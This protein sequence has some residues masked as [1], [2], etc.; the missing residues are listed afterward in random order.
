MRG[1]EQIAKSLV[2]DRA[3]PW[4]IAALLIVFLALVGLTFLGKPAS[5]MMII[6]DDDG[7]L[8][9]VEVDRFKTLLDRPLPEYIDWSEPLDQET[10]S[11]HYR[12][13]L[14]PG[15]QDRSLIARG[16]MNWI[17]RSPAI[18][19][20]TSTVDSNDVAKA[21]EGS[22]WRSQTRDKLVSPIPRSS[23]IHI[24]RIPPRKAKAKG[25]GHVRPDSD[26][27]AVWLKPIQLARRPLG[28]KT[29]RAVAGTANSSRAH[30]LEP[31]A[32]SVGWLFA[33]VQCDA[34]GGCKLSRKD[35]ADCLKP[36]TLADHV[37]GMTHLVIPRTYLYPSI[38]K[39]NSDKKQAK[40]GVTDLLEGGGLVLL[41][42]ADYDYVSLRVSHHPAG[43]PPPTD[44]VEKANA[45]V[46]EPADTNEK[47]DSKAEK[48][49]PTKEYS[50]AMLD[51]RL[52]EILAMINRAEDLND[53]DLVLILPTALDFNLGAG[54]YLI[55]GFDEIPP[56]LRSHYRG[57]PAESFS[58][59]SDDA[60]LMDWEVPDP[61][62]VAT[63][64]QSRSPAARI[65]AAV[66]E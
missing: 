23:K 30:E 64:T 3:K 37:L 17:A 28:D 65:S 12:R 63:T 14:R 18:E 50:I 39:E 15:D 16:G 20:I 4:F 32:Y 24:A 31:G 66:E 46:V 8:G 56:P 43:G 19:G 42:G 38:S 44:T 36:E 41:T 62:P 29:A 53:G 13:L 60:L 21:R 27:E 58:T 22:I 47:S 35:E 9:I 25:V 48:P 61:R 34:P 2:W 33:I 5:P 54:D 10:L 45:N 55:A 57:L 59:E 49:S 40:A 26:R 52:H 51:E 1:L 6:A 11:K 7:R